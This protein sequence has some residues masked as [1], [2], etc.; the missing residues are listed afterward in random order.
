MLRH[1]T[2]VTEYT[3]DTVDID[4]ST[5][6]STAPVTGVATARGALVTR[7]SDGLLFSGFG[8]TGTVT[9]LELHLTVSRLARIQDRVIQFYNA[10]STLG[11]NLADLAAEDTHIYRL[12]GAFDIGSDFGVIVDVGPHTQYPSANTVYIR[13][14]AVRFI[15]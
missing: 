6:V 2:T 13:S 1:Y 9:G 8:F 15:V 11:A 4:V 3:A 14:V 10:G 7:E 5:L 12:D